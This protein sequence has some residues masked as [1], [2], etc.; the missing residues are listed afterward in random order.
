MEEGEGEWRK[1]WRKKGRIKGW[2][3][4]AGESIDDGSGRGGEGGQRRRKEY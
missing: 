2:G 1:G 3:S 4:T